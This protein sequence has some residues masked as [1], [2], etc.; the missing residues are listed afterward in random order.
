M[1]SAEGK[2]PKQVKKP[3][4][5]GNFQTIYANDG[6]PGGAAAFTGSSYTAVQGAVTISGQT[7]NGGIPGS[8][9]PGLNIGINGN[10]AT[11][12]S[13]VCSPDPLIS[14]QDMETVFAN[15]WVNATFTGSCTLRLQ[16]SNNRYQG[17]TDYN[18]SAWLTFFTTTITGTG[19]GQTITM[20]N[21]SSGVENPKMS[22]RLTA[23]GT[24][25]SG[26]IDW[27]IPGLF[28]DYNAMGVGINAADANGG[29][30]QMSIQGP[31]YLTISGGQI[32]ATT[33]GNVPHSATKNN[34]D[35][36]G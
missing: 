17:T 30:G 31:R 9:V 5:L 1:Q 27:A 26:I 20:N 13:F 36:Y 10:G 25:A 23:S 33:N 12:V 28:V 34:V 32:T 15:L 19:S 11:D 24:T 4:V 7:W 16:G 21:T 14:L 6:V 18:S 29:I 8:A 22:Y 2:G 35:Y 3:Y